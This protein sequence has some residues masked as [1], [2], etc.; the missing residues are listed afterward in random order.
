MNDANQDINIEE[1]YQRIW[2]Q[3]QGGRDY[4]GFVIF[5]AELNGNMDGLKCV[6]PEQYQVGSLLGRVDVVDCLTLEQCAAMVCLYRTPTV[7]NYSTPTVNA[8]TR[9]CLSWRTRSN[10]R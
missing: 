9:L 3:Q 10:C 5:F 6:F 2:K 7:V 4:S 8:R 1:A